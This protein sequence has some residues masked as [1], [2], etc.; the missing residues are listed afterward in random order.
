MD[1]VSDG[2]RVPG[3]EILATQQVELQF[4]QFLEFLRENSVADSTVRGLRF[5]W[6]PLFFSV[7][8]SDPKAVSK[9]L[10]AGCCWF[11]IFSPVPF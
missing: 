10:E 4:P 5:H 7:K 2:T 9:F 6:F 8:I 11:Y 3:L 1:F